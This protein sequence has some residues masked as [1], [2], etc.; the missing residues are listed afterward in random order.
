MFRIGGS[1]EAMSLLSV[2]ARPYLLIPALCAVAVIGFGV[3]KSSRPPPLG[4][5]EPGIV[6]VYYTALCAR[7]GEA[8]DCGPVAGGKRVSFPTHEA[9]DAYRTQD[10]AKAA[11]PR[12]LGHCLKQR[13]S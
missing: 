7:A 1:R 11:D 10:L 8:T 3:A 6:W 12:L 9:C 4:T 5:E 2:I 13:E